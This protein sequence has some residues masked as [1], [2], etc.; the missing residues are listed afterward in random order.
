MNLLW[1]A[2]AVLSCERG[3]LGIELLRVGLERERVVGPA[4]AGAMP[5]AHEWAD[6]WA[7]V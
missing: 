2:Y 5:H 7:T 4:L 6:A 1:A 3:N